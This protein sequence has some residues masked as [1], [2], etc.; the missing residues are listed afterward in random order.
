MVAP[1]NAAVPAPATVKARA[2]HPA[3]AMRTAIPA[4]R[5]AG[6]GVTPGMETHSEP[7]ASTPTSCDSGRLVSAPVTFRDAVPALVPL[8]LLEALRNLDTPIE[9]G[10]EE[11][12]PEIV[13]R[14]FGLSPTV[15]LQIERYTA[16]RSASELVSREEAVGVLRLVGR[17]PDAELALADAGRRAARYAGRAAR[18]ST[19]TV[20]RVSPHG[21]GRKLAVRAAAGVAN[22][23]FG[24]EI[25]RGAAEIEIRVPDPLTIASH[26]G[27]EACGFYAALFAELF[28]VVV[29]MEGIFEHARCRGRGDASCNWVWR[30]AGDY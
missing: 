21:L 22:E 13:A 7:D 18:R 2:F 12:S 16:A 29:G 14:R 3:A 27:G 24:A 26:P 23:Y 30:E 19:G 11:R 8:S 15:A 4:A 6:G 5:A 9:D 10:L 25:E 1:S 28:R 17:R 20:V